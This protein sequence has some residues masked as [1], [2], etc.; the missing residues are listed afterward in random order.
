MTNLK[1]VVSLWD[2][3]GGDYRK[4]VWEWDDNNLVEASKSECVL[5][6]RLLLY[7]H[8]SSFVRSVQS[9]KDIFIPKDI[10]LIS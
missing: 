7:R 1:G 9:D 10:V 6:A 4:G 5:C 8:P 3:A 2:S